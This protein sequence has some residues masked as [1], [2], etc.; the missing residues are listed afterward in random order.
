MSALLHN[1]G[2]RTH[3]DS[4]AIT[5]SASVD[6]LVDRQGIDMMALTV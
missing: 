4:S 5:H 1:S 3:E 2:G 6:I